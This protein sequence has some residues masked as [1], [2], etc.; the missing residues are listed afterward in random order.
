MENF[1]ATG[2]FNN[3]TMDIDKIKEIVNE[4]LF[5]EN[6]K[7]RLIIVELSKDEDVVP[8]ILGILNEERIA[9]KEMVVDMNI[10]IGGIGEFCLPCSSNIWIL[11]H[12][13][14]S[15]NSNNPAIKACGYNAITFNI[16]NTKY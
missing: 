10:L 4:D 14:G 15:D 6:V 2:L 13:S 12:S 11:L 5:S 3:K 7:E 1:V 9:K 8:T 16:T